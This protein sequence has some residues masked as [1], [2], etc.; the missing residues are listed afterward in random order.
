MLSL[1]VAEVPIN[2]IYWDFPNVT[3]V[4]SSFNVSA[5]NIKSLTQ[6]PYVRV[7]F[8]FSSSPPP[9]AVSLGVPLPPSTFVYVISVP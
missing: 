3:I 5:D 8:D 6:L 1:L 2:G 9:F 4:T 7:S